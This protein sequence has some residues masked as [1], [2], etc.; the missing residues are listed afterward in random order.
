MRLTIKLAIK[1][2]DA[3]FDLD[4]RNIYKVNNKLIVISYISSHGCGGEKITMVSDSITVETNCANTLPIKHYAFVSSNLR[5]YKKSF[6]TESGLSATVIE[7]IDGILEI[8]G[9]DIAA[10][11][12]Y[13]EAA[14]M[15]N[16]PAVQGYIEANKTN[17]TSLNITSLNGNTALILAAING[18]ENIVDLLLAIPGINLTAKNH[19]QRTAAEEA[20]FH[21]NTDISNKISEKYSQYISNLQDIM[22]ERSSRFFGLAEDVRVIIRNY[23]VSQSTLPNSSEAPASSSADVA[24]KP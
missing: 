15:G 12:G 19:N 20:A 7:S 11:I 8:R 14:A 22:R 21:K 16:L 1:F 24:L 13:L 10:E 2:P 9:S 17:L 18:H 4:I 3:S 5:S 23:V 6:Q